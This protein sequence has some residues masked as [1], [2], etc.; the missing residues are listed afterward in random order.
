MSPHRAH[1]LV[2]LAEGAI[3]YNVFHSKTVNSPIFQPTFYLKTVPAALFSSKFHSKSV[4]CLM[5]PQTHY[6]LV[7]RAE[8]GI[9]RK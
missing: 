6:S 5:S 3:F 8:G 4:P 2:I 9:K 1:S 7:I